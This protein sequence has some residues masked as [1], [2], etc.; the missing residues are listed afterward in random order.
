MS[1]VTQQRR[2]SASFRDAHG[3]VTQQHPAASGTSGRILAYRRDGTTTP[4]L[5]P[6]H[7]SSVVLCP[8]AS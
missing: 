1:V 6:P 8:G 4:P 5:S 2:A 7:G 3:T